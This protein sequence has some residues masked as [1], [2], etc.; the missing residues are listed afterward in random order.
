MSAYA[1]LLSNY[2]CCSNN[3][4]S[5]SM[6]QRP[7]RWT[8]RRIISSLAIVALVAVYLAARPSLE[9][10][11]GL[12]LPG[13]RNGTHSAETS[14]SSDRSDTSDTSKSNQQTTSPQ[15]SNPTAS[16]E[17]LTDLGN[18]KFQSP[19]GLIYTQ[20]RN[21]EHRIDHVMRHTKNDEN[22]DVHGVFDDTNQDNLLKLLD[23]AYR[24][25]LSQ[26]KRVERQSDR[27]RMTYSCD[28]QRRV[29]Y[30]GGQSGKKKG[31]PDCQWIKLVLEGNRV[32]TAYPI[33]RR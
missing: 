10:M 2:L 27:S 23:D 20:G 26:S 21:G 3:H 18:K 12:Q 17:F 31:N 8:K 22:R 33:N 19:A 25:I 30:V 16:Q 11:T 9:R 4:E 29:G 1:L 7:Q 28:M 5:E 14:N 32:I 15:D 13:L 24:M 6:N